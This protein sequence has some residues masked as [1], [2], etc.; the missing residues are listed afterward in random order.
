MKACILCNEVKPLSEYY[1]HKAMSDGYLGRCKECH[2][3]EIKKNR[4][5]NSEYYRNYDAYRYK[6]DPRVKQRH[7]RYLSTTEGIAAIRRGQKK[8]IINNPEKRAAH[9]MVS[10]AVRSGRLLK[11]TN[12]PV[13]GGF[14]PRREIHAHHNDYTR[15]LEVEWMCA[16]CHAN[17]HKT[18]DTTISPV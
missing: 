11:P 14:K 5:K 1:R 10:N 3:S 16:K 15:P 9:I 12:C 7:N 17:H 6:N 13:C 2:K 8:F 4:D 18:I